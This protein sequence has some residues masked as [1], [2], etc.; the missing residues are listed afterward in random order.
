M[1]P[2][3][4]THKGWTDSQFDDVFVNCFFESNTLEVYRP[5]T[6]N[7]KINRIKVRLT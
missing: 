7:F 6:R 1:C 5:V 4:P 2:K 3:D